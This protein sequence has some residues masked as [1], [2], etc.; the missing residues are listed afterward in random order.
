MGFS[1]VTPEVRIFTHG[2]GRL[3]DLDPADFDIGLS[4]DPAAPKPWVGCPPSSFA[5]TCAAL[6][7]AIAR[8]ALA[9]GVAAQ[10]LRMTL[11]LPFEEALILESFAYS[12]LLG[13]EGFKTWRAERPVRR[14]QDDAA[15]RVS[16][17]RENGG[18]TITLARPKLRN[19]VDRRMRDELADALDFALVDPDQDPVRLIGEGSAFCAGGDLDSFGEAADPGQAHAIRLEQSATARVLALGARITAT[20]HGA[21]VGAGIEIPA[22]AHRVIALPDTHFQLPEVS[23]GLIPGAGGTASITRRIGRHRACYMAV[24]GATLDA[25]TAL[26]WG[27]VDAVVEGP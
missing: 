14:R 12:M 24:S 6:E 20:L 5:A 10:V 25:R 2:E 11:A 22:A 13:S 8:Q 1:S 4:V 3:P 17:T 18:L 9:A 15:P 16:L 23:M 27:L 19:A 21:C 26:A 7:A